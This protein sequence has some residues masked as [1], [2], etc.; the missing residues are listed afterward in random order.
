[1]RQLQILVKFRRK[2]SCSPAASRSHLGRYQACAAGAAPKSVV[3]SMAGFAWARSVPSPVASAAPVVTAASGG[4]SPESGGV[5]NSTPKSVVTPIGRH[6]GRWPGSDADRRSRC[7][8]DDCG[9]MSPQT[10]WPYSNPSFSQIGCRRFAAD[11]RGLLNAP[12]RPSQPPQ[13][14]DLLFRLLV[15]DVA[16]IDA[17]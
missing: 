13:R 16:H 7:V 5:A 14:D 15:Q 17:G 3:T 4:A 1:M 10:W 6:C 12:Q 2:P 8:V 9:P 11:A